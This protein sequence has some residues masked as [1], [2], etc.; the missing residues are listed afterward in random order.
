MI[1]GSSAISNIHTRTTFDPYIRATMKSNSF[2][3]ER[4]FAASSNILSPITFGEDTKVITFN[5]KIVYYT[6]DV[7]SQLQYLVTN[8]GASVTSAPLQYGISA[9]FING[10]SWNDLTQLYR[11]DFHDTGSTLN[12]YFLKVGTTNGTDYISNIFR[13]SSNNGASWSGVTVVN[14]TTTTDTFDYD[15][16]VGASE[17]Y[18]TM[19]CRDTHE[20]IRYGTI[21]VAQSHMYTDMYKSGE[22]T[23]GY[24]RLEFLEFDNNNKYIVM[25]SGG[26]IKI[27]TTEQIYNP[28]YFPYVTLMRVSRNSVFEVKK[29]ASV[30]YKE[31]GL[32]LVYGAVG[33]SYGYFGIRRYNR[34]IKEYT[35]E[36]GTYEELVDVDNFDTLHKIDPNGYLYQRVIRSSETPIVSYARSGISVAALPDITGYV[37]SGL[38]IYMY[39]FYETYGASTYI[40]NDIISY[41]NQDNKRITLEV[42]NT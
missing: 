31:D 21:G 23:R 41:S 24:K 18:Y 5:N 22:F 17:T 20:I 26:Q 40:T 15:L 28:A 27:T 42:S 11:G 38:L 39:P 14:T 9:G 12:F 6:N 33:N 10:V 13:I 1:S 32:K 37:I 30:D 35:S 29:I 7:E 25:E 3:G 4:N 2:L 8:G 34:E 16:A 36:F 19:A